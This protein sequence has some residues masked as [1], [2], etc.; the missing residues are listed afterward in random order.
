MS[1]VPHPHLALDLAQ[2]VARHLQRDEHVNR[3][4]Y[5]VSVRHDFAPCD[6]CAGEQ[7]PA[8]LGWWW[9]RP[10]AT[11]DGSAETCADW[12]CVRAV[13]SEALEDSKPEGITVEH[14]VLA[15]PVHEDRRA[16]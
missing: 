2:L 4:S 3:E 11:T 9:N 10:G 6:Y 7:R 1:A 8:I 15:A 13:L 5:E 12:D 16:A 14:P